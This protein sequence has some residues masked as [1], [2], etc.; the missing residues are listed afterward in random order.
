MS[1]VLNTYKRD[2]LLNG[3][4][5][6]VF[7]HGLGAQETWVSSAF[8]WKTKILETPELDGIDVGIVTYDTAHLVSGMF[9]FSGKV[10]LGGR[11]L[12][13][14]QGNFS[15]IA[16]LAH[17]LQ[18]ELGQ[19]DLRQYRKIVLIGHSMGG[20]IGMHYILQ[21]LDHKGS[22]QIGGFI[23][24][25]T[26]YNG[27]DLAN[28]HKLIRVIQS[29]TQISD[30]APNSN[31]LDSTN[32][33]LNKYAQSPEVQG[34]DP[35]FYY[36]ITDE[37]V[38][39]ESAIPHSFPIWGGG[40][41]LHGNHSSILDFTQSSSTVFREVHDYL[42]D[43]LDLCSKSNETQSFVGNEIKSINP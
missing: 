4:V 24:L 28:Y 10:Q 36:G 43:V 31:F 41:P 32:R 14:H 16:E 27:A 7:I 37:I 34:I 20:L 19:R 15:D 11:E 17:Q 42:L 1:L 33:L 39:K 29:H 18:R 40:L 25:A 8:D 38:P 5:L 3:Q 12:T 23:S 30:L 21:E 26:P 6:A 9:K 2:S 35:R 13:I 22:I